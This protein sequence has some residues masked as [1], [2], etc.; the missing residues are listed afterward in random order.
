MKPP[1]PRGDFTNTIDLFFDCGGDGYSL[2]RMLLVTHLA[3]FLIIKNSSQRLE[4]NV[5]TTEFFDWQ[6]RKENVGTKSED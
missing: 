3:F 2:W 6:V 4:L 1:P 5:K